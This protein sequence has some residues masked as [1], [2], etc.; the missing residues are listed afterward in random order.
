MVGCIRIHEPYTSDSTGLY[1][2]VIQQ[3]FGLRA[4]VIDFLM[5]ASLLINSVSFIVCG[6][7]VGVC[8][9]TEAYENLFAYLK[10]N[11][12][13]EEGRDLHRNEL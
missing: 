9:Y 3:Y 12:K 4:D 10:N 7:L 11:T 6:R 2:G 13:R 8:V 1:V 5:P